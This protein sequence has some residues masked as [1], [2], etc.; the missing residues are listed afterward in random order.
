MSGGQLGAVRPSE[1]LPE[2]HNF[3]TW[4]YDPHLAGGTNL[5]TSG[6]VILSGLPLRRRQTISTLYYVQGVAGVTPTAGQ[7]F[8]GLYDSSGNLLQSTNIDAQVTATA[9]QLVTVA[10]TATVCPAG[11]YY[12]ALLFN[13]A[14]V[15]QLLKGSGAFAAT[16]NVGLAAPSLRSM[17]VATA[18]TALP[19]PAVLA[20]GTVDKGFWAALA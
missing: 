11:R 9:G 5:Q 12:F 14:T 20:S 17:K 2:D 7:N 4:T 3:A 18:A 13:A 10:I 1:W 16:N 15:P 6:D 8:A 19:S